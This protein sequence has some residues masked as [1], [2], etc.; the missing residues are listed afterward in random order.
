MKNKVLQQN[1][2]NM[3]NKKDVLLYYNLHFIDW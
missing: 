2:V 1:A 3:L